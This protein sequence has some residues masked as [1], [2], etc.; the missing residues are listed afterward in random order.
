[1]EAS[2]SFFLKR[3]YNTYIDILKIRED[4]IC[5][6]LPGLYIATFQW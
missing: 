4:M 5:R 6:I 1:M 3:A 2:I